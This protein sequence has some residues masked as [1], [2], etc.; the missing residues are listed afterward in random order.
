MPAFTYTIVRWRGPHVY[1]KCACGETAHDARF[2][3]E[4]A[5]GLKL[6]YYPCRN[7]SKLLEFRKS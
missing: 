2:A 1:R 4:D 3:F 7:C 5:V 6:F